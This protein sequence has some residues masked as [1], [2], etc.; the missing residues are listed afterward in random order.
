M[1]HFDAVQI[2]CQRHDSDA[3]ETNHWSDGSGNFLTRAAHAKVWADDAFHSF[4]S[5][6][7]TQQSDEEN[8]EEM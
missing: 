7:V 3:D 5:D 4:Q 8:D 2:L 1:E 6:P